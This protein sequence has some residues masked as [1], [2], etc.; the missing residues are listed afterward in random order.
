M[1]ERIS[2]A[3]TQSASSNLTFIQF[4][5]R[6]FHPRDFAVELWDGTRW[7]PERNQFCRFTWKIN[8][9]GVL[10]AVFDSGN[11][12]LALGEAYVEGDFDITGDIEAVFPLADYLIGKQWGTIEKLQIASIL[13]DPP[14]LE[15]KYGGRSRA[16]ISGELHSKTRDQQAIKYHYDVSNDFYQL[17]LDRNMLYS[18][19]YFTNPSE[20]LDSAQIQKMDHVCDE[21]GL[22]PGE[23]LVDIGC[24]WGGFIIHATRE[25]GVQAVGITISQSQA[26]L[27]QRRIQAAGLSD[28][29][30]VR[31]LDYRDL[32]ELGVCDKLVSIGMVEHV[33]GSNLPEYFRRAYRVLRPGGMFFNSG[34]VRASNRLPSKSSTFTDVYVFPDGEL[35]TIAAMLS[36]AEDAGF[37]VRALEN[38]REHYFYTTKRWLQRLEARAD[39]ARRIVGNVRYRT[40]RLYLAGSTYYFQKG[41]LDLYQT[42][43]M[44]DNKADASQFLTCSSD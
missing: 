41:W 28:R 17:W 1:A 29:C 24:G 26:D 25:Y 38:L 33:G 15:R 43:L 13:R 23:R 11:R 8:N 9:P 35:T 27:A 18:C 44:K 12:Q 36:N 34:I 20:D 14:L 16:N 40:W 42:L 31:R 39:E 7:A 3:A 10:R 6:D 2:E 30:Q 32:D 37:E 22:K 19:A 21:L 4:L 5:L